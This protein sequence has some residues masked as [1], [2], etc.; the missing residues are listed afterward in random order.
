MCLCDL[1]FSCETLCVPPQHPWP[2]QSTRVPV[3][4]IHFTP[5]HIFYSRHT[6][7]NRPTFITARI[8]KALLYKRLPLGRCLIEKL[9]SSVLSKYN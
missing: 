9:V 1:V 4:S 5:P 6:H 7:C 8:K 2:D 3:I